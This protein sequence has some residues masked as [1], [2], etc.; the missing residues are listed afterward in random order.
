MPAKG[1][2]GE[3]SRSRIETRA[4]PDFQKE[5]DTGGWQSKGREVDGRTGPPE[6]LDCRRGACR[7]H[8]IARR[9]RFLKTNFRAPHVLDSSA[10][11]NAGEG[12]AKSAAFRD[13]DA[14]L[15]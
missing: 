2:G 6:A 4:K 7:E 11:S 14:K 5:S 15:V 12:E 9:G 10:V 8:L 3:A 1:G 13:G